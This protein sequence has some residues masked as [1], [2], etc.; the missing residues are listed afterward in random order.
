[1]TLDSTYWQFGAVTGAVLH[2]AGAPRVVPAGTCVPG[3]GCGTVTLTATVVAAGRAE[4]TA[5]RTTCGEVVRCSPAESSFRV[6]VLA[7]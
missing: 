3:G 1:V 5:S 7:R 6:V 2:A 4:I